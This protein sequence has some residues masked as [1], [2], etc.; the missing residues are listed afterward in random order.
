MSQANVRSVDAIKDFKLAMIAFAEDARNALGGVEMEIR[1]VRNWLERDQLAYWKGQIKRCNELVAE[2]RSELHRRK[3]SQGNS[4]AVSDADQKEALRLAQRRLR[5]AEEKVEHIKRWIPVLEHAVA[6][7][8]SQS[9]PL[10]DRLA[11]RFEASVALLERMI[12]AVEQYLAMNAPTGTL[13]PGSAAVTNAGPASAGG[14]ATASAATN[15]DAAPSAA[16]AQT[17]TPGAPPAQGASAAASAPAS[18]PGGDGNV[19]VEPASQKT[20]AG[21]S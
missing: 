17:A 4:D 11:G 7:Y 9:Q 15:G 13:V 3:L 1:H 20:A 12:I 18:A 21:A 14:K 5:E 6:E 2:A 10:G 19:V 8:H 16:P